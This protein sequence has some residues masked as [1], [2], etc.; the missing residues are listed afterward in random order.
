MAVIAPTIDPPGP[1]GNRFLGSLLDMQKGIVD[2]YV[3]IWR[4]YG[5]VAQFK[6]GPLNAFLFVR[7]EHV[8]HIMVKNVDNYTKGISHD[9][10]RTS[11]GNGI[12][13]LEGTPWRKQRKLM[14]PSYTPTSIT[15]YAEL[16]QEA[17]RDLLQRWDRQA[18]SVIDINQEMTTVTM[19]VISRAMFGLDIGAHAKEAAAALHQ[20]LEYTASGAGKII[21][22][23]LFI[24]VPRNQKLKRAK[25]IMGEFIYGIIEQRRKEGLRDDLLSLLMSSKDADTGEFM[26]DEQLHDE[27]LI[28]IFAGHE[29]TASLLTWAFYLLSQH[30]DVERKL[31]AE[32]DQVLAGRSPQLEDITQLTY[33]RMVLDETLRLYSPV[34]M[35]AR[36][37]VADDVVEQ[38]PVSAKSMVVIMPYITHRHPDFWERPYA[39]YPEHFAPEQVEKRPRYAYY[40]FGAGQR[41]CIGNHFALME[42]MLIL[43]EVAQRYRPQLAAPN[44]GGIN[45]VGVARPAKPILMRLEKR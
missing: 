5:D 26:T 12:L 18:G 38:F 40:P 16:M 45:F 39:F 29:T 21:E 36:D 22:L 4:E 17:S 13:T 31:H 20:L 14:Q 43:A 32:L 11:I 30:A 37:V 2:F 28:T 42:A 10:L 7:P 41:I 15:R 1:K 19:S 35:M 24:P 8:Q 6:L 23:P 27:V 33:A 3:D 44:E 9:R 34:V 25:Q